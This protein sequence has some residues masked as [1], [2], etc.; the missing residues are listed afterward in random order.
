MNYSTPTFTT[1]ATGKL[2]VLWHDSH[3][4]GMNGTQVGVFE[5]SYQVNF[6]S[7]LQNQDCTSLETQVS[8]EILSDFTYNALEW[9]LADRKLS[10]LLVTTIL[11]IARL[12]KR[13]ILRVLRTMRLNGSL[14]IK[15]SVIFW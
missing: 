15:S 7:F 12:W 9:Q 4:F 1:N 10:G 6:S 8:L 14:R 3:S 2:D 13:Q 11:T 5:K